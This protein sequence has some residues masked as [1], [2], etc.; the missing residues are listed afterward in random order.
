MAARL[1]YSEGA[2]DLNLQGFATDISVDH[3]QTVSFKINDAARVSYHIDIYRMGYYGGAGAR[4][5][6]T[7]PAAQIVENVQP[8]PLSDTTTGR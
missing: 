8:A 2:G 7:I 4:K 3:G 6:A 5:V 1:R